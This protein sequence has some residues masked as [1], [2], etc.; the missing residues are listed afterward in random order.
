MQIKIRG[1]AKEVERD[2]LMTILVAVLCGGVLSF[3]IL[4]AFFNKDKELFI[5][6]MNRDKAVAEAIIENCLVFSSANSSFSPDGTL[7]VSC[8]VDLKYFQKLEDMHKRMEKLRREKA[9]KSST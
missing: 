4:T 6:Q 7:S 5:A 3:L 2:I 8:N 9:K 1:D